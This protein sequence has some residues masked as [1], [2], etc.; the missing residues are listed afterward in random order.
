MQID[1]YYEK[2][3]QKQQKL[4]TAKATTKMPYQYSSL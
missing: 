1:H 4:A 2:Q 3:Q